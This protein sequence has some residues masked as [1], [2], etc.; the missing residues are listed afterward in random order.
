[1]FSISDF[2]DLIEQQL[3]HNRNKS[4][5]YE[6]ANGRLV[7]TPSEETVALFKQRAND[8]ANFI[9]ST[10][11]SGTSPQIIEY[12]SDQTILLFMEAN[13]YLNFTEQDSR[14]LQRIYNDL[15]EQVY[16]MANQNDISDEEIDQLFH[17]HYKKLQTF[18]LESN[19]GD[20][21]IK[22]KDRPVL[23]TVKSAEYSAEFQMRILN[24]HLSDIKMPFLD[25]GCGQQASLVHFLRKNGI[26]AYGIDRIAQNVSYLQKA[27]WCDFSF[28]PYTW[29]TIISHMAFSNHFIHHHLRIDG[30]Y[31]VYAKKYMEILRSLKHGGSFIYTPSLS[32]MEKIL[33]SANESYAVETS[34][35]S[36]KVLRIN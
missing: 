23:F 31:D 17:S 22:Y 34:D 1:M 5:F 10:V 7:L 25:I 16:K 21:F 32:F 33:V 24:I 20:I 9:Q 19:G 8:I 29:G 12:L 3:C 30:H 2:K 36:T 28:K 27:N 35:Y 13:Q 26:E 11:K 15:F 4:L 18:L 14:H 6:L